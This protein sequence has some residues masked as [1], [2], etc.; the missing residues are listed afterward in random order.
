MLSAAAPR[1]T[2]PD[3]TSDRSRLNRPVSWALLSLLGILLV[4]V[5]FESW[6]QILLAP[7]HLDENGLGVAD[8]PD[9]PKNLKNGLYLAVA[10]LTAVKITLDR[11]W[12]DFRTKADIAI[13]GLAVLLVIAGLA[14]GSPL[15]LIGEGVFVYLR[16]AIVF[17]AWRALD[18]TWRWVRPL[19][20]ILGGF[21][22][23]NALIACLQM[24]IGTASYR[25]LGWVDMTWAKIYRAH[26][27]LDHPN[28]LGHLAGVAL[29]GLLAWFVTKDSIRRRWWV[30]FG[31][32]ALGMSATQSRESAI[33]FMAGAAL[34]WILRRGQTRTVVAAVLVV[35][36]FVSAQIAFRPKNRA[37]LQ[38]R[39]IGVV[40]A[41]IL[42]SGTEPENFCVK[43][44]PECD[45][46]ANGIPQREIRILYAQQG[47]HLWAQR[48]ILGYGVGQFGGIV[49]F[50]HDPLWYQDP[51]FG[52]KGFNLYGFNA[53]QVDSFW[54]HLIVE[55]GLAGLIGYLVWLLFLALPLLRSLLAAR[56]TRIRGPTGDTGE[57]GTAGAAVTWPAGSPWA[58]WALSALLF[59]VLIATM[60]SSLEDPLFPPIL[61]T[62]L[63]LAWVDL[64]RPVR[65]AE[66]AAQPAPGLTVVG[67]VEPAQAPPGTGPVSG[68]GRA[69]QRASVPQA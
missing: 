66:P 60:S 69:E 17:Y 18:P 31:L 5:L 43:G 30:L 7:V 11:R 48:P 54:L 59:G 24:A 6:I 50:K 39:I 13:S 22:A 32:V 29:L 45:E 47:A 20:W 12:R 19:L 56:R 27:L 58:Y 36:L 2:T 4:E 9:W 64:R 21:V 1:T 14:G 52:P 16:G 51:R 46:D 15:S 23:L 38:R 44:N 61:F 63:G 57:A 34:I 3:N 55:T 41:L 33:A 28:H 67:D 10:V 62:I 40:N 68:N 35:A 49:A 53:Q 65:P 8:L 42:R 26:A 25:W 37:E